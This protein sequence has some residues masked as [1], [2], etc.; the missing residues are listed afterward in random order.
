MNLV[1]CS[2]V[3]GVFKAGMWVGLI[4]AALVVALLFGVSRAF[5]RR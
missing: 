1:G 2:L 3:K 5:S 4:G